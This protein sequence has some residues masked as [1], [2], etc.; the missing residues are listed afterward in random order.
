MQLILF[1]KMRCAHDDTKKSAFIQQMEYSECGLACLAMLL[2][3]YRHHTDLNQ[4]REEY[5]APRGGYSLFNLVE[6]AHNKHFE[7][8]AFERIPGT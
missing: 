7:T 2:N 3:Y 5:P 6:I 8:E 4:L 1:K